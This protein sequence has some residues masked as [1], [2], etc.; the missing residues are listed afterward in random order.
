M[1]DQPL[2]MLK[3]IG[4]IPELIPEKDIFDN[5]QEYFKQ[6]KKDLI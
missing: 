5:V 4:I 2:E 3:G 1:Q 6:V